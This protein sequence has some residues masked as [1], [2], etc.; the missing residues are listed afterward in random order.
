MN[1]KCDLSCMGYQT[2]I[3]NGFIHSRKKPTQM[4]PDL[5]NSPDSQA[6]LKS[7]FVLVCVNIMVDNGYPAMQK[8]QIGR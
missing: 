6:W 8:A 3:K 2:A 5:Q 7:P 4:H 1:F